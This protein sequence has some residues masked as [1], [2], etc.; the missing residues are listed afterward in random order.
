MS[1]LKSEVSIKKIELD[2]LRPSMVLA[3]DVFTS[4]GLLIMSKNTMLTNN[5]CEKLIANDINN[6]YI[7]VD[8]FDEMPNPVASSG[9]KSQDSIKERIEIRKVEEKENYKD[10]SVEYLK[11]TKVIK[12][13]LKGIGNGATIELKEL[14]NLTSGVMG[15]IKCKSDVFTFLSVIESTDESTYTHSNNVALLA[16]LFG[17]WLGFD[18]A[19]MMNITTAGMLHDLGK[20]LVDQETLNKKEPLTKEEFEEI[21][22]HPSLGYKV[23]S[24]QNLPVEIKLAALMHHEKMDGTGYPLKVKSE[25]INNFAKIIAICD[26]YDAMTAN[27]IYRKKIIPFEVIRKLE[28]HS[29]G[30][31]DTNFL[32]VF[33]NNIAYNYIGSWVRLSDERVGEI[34][35]INPRN[36]SRPM[37]K[38][39][40]DI[41]DLEKNP[42]LEI[43]ELL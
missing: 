11:K 32:L 17:S 3:K 33:L 35:F 2:E 13:T 41:V 15:K 14:Y 31:L 26:I 1:D 21:K 25:Q 27:R 36:L 9:L 24:E 23:M 19:N 34:I 18:E 37:I 43:L 12:D 22:R 6:I 5:S 4:T 8:K 7:I 42:N 30:K 29:Y 10:F 20:T 39:G 38:I 28:V 16:N 40:N